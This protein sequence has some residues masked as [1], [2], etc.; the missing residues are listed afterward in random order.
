MVRQRI[1]VLTERGA[2]RVPGSDHG[3][4]RCRRQVHEG[5]PGVV[6]R[7]KSGH[8]TGPGYRGNHSPRACDMAAGKTNMSVT[9]ANSA[10]TL[11]GLLGALCC[12]SLIFPVFCGRTDAVP[13]P[14]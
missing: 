6:R 7:K 3:G 11:A 5:A 4:A 14:K 1:R 9:Y 8:I 10:F 2:G 13:T 12:I